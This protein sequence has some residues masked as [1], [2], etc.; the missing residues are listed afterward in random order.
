MSDA[1][2]IAPEDLENGTVHENLEAGFLRSPPTPKFAQHSKN[3]TIAEPHGNA[4][5]G[6]NRRLSS[7]AKT[8]APPSPNA[9][10]DSSQ[11]A[12]PKIRVPYSDIA[13][14]AFTGKDTAAG[15][16]KPG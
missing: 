15:A 6:E 4:E 12:A 8:T 16:S 11:R 1:I 13:A 2:K 14:L 7:I 5:S 3:P 10:F 9:I